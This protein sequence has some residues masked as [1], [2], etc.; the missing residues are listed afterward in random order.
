MTRAS[1]YDAS[2]QVYWHGWGEAKD[3]CSCECSD[4]VP[5]LIDV[6]F[7]NGFTAIPFNPISRTWYASGMCRR[8]KRR[9]NFRVEDGS[10]PYYN[11]DL[12]FEACRMLNIHGCNHPD[13]LMGSYLIKDADGNRGF[14]IKCKKCLT[15]VFVPRSN[16]SDRYRIE[17]RHA[18]VE[19]FN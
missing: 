18:F 12:V 13:Y 11:D 7:R 4:S 14:L 3:A 9:L 10:A 2:D 16:I 19:K 6:V 15:E 1:D 5:V 8:C 17:N